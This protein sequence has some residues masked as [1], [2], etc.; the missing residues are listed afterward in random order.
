ML[1]I[2]TLLEACPLYKKKEGYVD[3]T[4]MVFFFFSS[5]NR[6]HPR[7]LLG[8]VSCLFKTFLCSGLLVILYFGVHLFKNISFNFHWH[9]FLTP[10]IQF[11]D[12]LCS[13]Q[14][15]FFNRSYYYVGILVSAQDT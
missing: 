13:L 9:K 3:F 2:S 8:C 5:A 10:C 4:F 1:K 12:C 11:E 15:C 14:C 6:F 7:N